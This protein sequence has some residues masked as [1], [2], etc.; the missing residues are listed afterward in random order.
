[1]MTA[2]VA[3]PRGRRRLRRP[4]L[5]PEARWRCVQHGQPHTQ[6]VTT[7]L[8]NADGTRSVVEGFRFACSCERFTIVGRVITAAEFAAMEA[9]LAQLHGVA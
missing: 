8:P 7:S 2:S 1:M 4:E 3:R 5:S 6:L 9:R